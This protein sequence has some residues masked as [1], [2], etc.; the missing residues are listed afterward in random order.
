MFNQLNTFN[1]TNAIVVFIY[2]LLFTQHVCLF[3]DLSRFQKYPLSHLNYMNAGLMSALV[4]AG[5]FF[6]LGF[7]S[8]TNKIMCV[9]AI[10]IVS[11]TAITLTLQ[12]LSNWVFLREKVSA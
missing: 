11:A 12:R 5:C 1:A 6:T 3:V 8:G 10:G 9:T 2:A 7:L 4:T